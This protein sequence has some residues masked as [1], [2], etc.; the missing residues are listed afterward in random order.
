MS[1]LLL[2]KDFVSVAGLLTEAIDAKNLAD[3]VLHLLRWKC[4]STGRAS[5]VDMNRRAR[6]F[7][8]KVISKVPVIPASLVVT[9][10]IM[11]A[12]RNYIGSGGFGRVF[13]GEWKGKIVALKVLY[14]SDNQVVRIS[15]SL[16]IVVSDFS[17]NRNSV[18]RL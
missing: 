8:L 12:E 5:A 4:L 3:F 2:R 13:K 11:P 18:E 1:K 17:F 10:I 9:G 6:R 14:K 15:A 7:M 16:Y